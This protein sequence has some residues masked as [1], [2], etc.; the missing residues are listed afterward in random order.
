MVI[1]REANRAFAGLKVFELVLK[2]FREGGTGGIERTVICPRAEINERSSVELKP[3]ESVADA[4]FH[5]GCD[6]VNG[7][8]EFL[9]HGSLPG[10]R[11]REVLVNGFGDCFG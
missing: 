5:V 6:G 2:L 3:S 1:R 8:A 11:T 4:L 7:L 9:Q 10:F